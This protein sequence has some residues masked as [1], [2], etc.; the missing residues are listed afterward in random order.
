MKEIMTKAKAKELVHENTESITKIIDVSD[1]IRQNVDSWDNVDI[2]LLKDELY[3]S[4]SEW[5]YQATH[6]YESLIQELAVGLFIESMQRVPYDHLVF[7]S[8]DKCVKEGYWLHDMNKNEI[9]NRVIKNKNQIE[10]FYEYE[11]ES[12]MFIESCVIDSQVKELEQ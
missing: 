3:D 10:Y 7:E 12:Q 8:R 11:R 1:L 9:L 4:L 6:P 2:D 5:S